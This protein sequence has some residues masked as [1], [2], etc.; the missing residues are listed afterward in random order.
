MPYHLVSIGSR[1]W[2]VKDDKGHY[3][4]RNPLPKQR[5]LAQQRALY[6]NTTHTGKG[7]T[8]Y[9]MGDNTHYVM[10]GKGRFT[11]FIKKGVKKVGEFA[12]KLVAPGLKAVR[13]LTTPLTRQNAFPPKVR[14]FI[15]QNKTCLV[16]SAYA[17]RFPIYDVLEKVLNFISAN[18]FGE[19]KR[20]LGYDK[21]FHLSLV[22]GLQCA[23][24]R[25][26]GVMIEK[27][28][29]VNITTDYKDD[30]PETQL[31]QIPVP[32]AI[33]FGSFIQ[34][35]VDAIGPSIYQY[36]A[37]QNN[38]QLFVR[39]ILQANGLLNPQVQGFIMQDSLSLIQ[40]LPDYVG[41]FA[42]VITNI[43]GIADRFIEG[44][45]KPDLVG[46]GFFDDVGS[47]FK[48]TFTGQ[49]DTYPL[50]PLYDIDAEVGPAPDKAGLDE[51]IQ[52]RQKEEFGKAR[53]AKFAVNLEKQN[54]PEI[55][56]IEN[57]KATRY[58]RARDKL[59]KS[60]LSTVQV[61]SQLR[62]LGD[63]APYYR[64]FM[65][66]QEY[67]KYDTANREARG[68]GPSSECDL[69]PG[70]AKKDVSVSSYLDPSKTNEFPLLKDRIALCRHLPAGRG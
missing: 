39:N 47:W 57:M 24:G 50:Q 11:E 30:G 1:G 40:Q 51:Y 54:D 34:K 14:A 48:T 8:V 28:E 36:D 13:D 31:F 26:F 46:S 55:R 12:K 41:P 56:R 42:R 70:L 69:N 66:K 32:V 33:P 59:Y 20:S 68:V 64:D 38:C 58:E 7:Y 67:C 29:V 53:S 65:T 9:Q 44:E 2:K 15:E 45:G 25:K 37:F 23:D 16:K 27:N 19:I 5:A 6:A 17:R 35:A 4:S 22:V 18:R 52:K 43:A 3:Y 62:K 21:M 49:R 63:S 61:N 10:H 60:G